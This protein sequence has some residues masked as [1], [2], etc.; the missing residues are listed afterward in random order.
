VSMA[1]TTNTEVYT[2]PELCLKVRLFDLIYQIK[3]LEFKLTKFCFMEVD[4]PVL[5]RIKS[6]VE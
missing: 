2:V 1:H 5:S 4:T 6:L 3:V